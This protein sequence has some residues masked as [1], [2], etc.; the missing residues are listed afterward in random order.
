[1]KHWKID[2]S[3]KTADGVQEKYLFVEAHNIDDALAKAHK[4]VATA[5]LK[6]S[7]AGD[8]FVIWDVGMMEEEVF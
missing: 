6:E 5:E 2:Y 1:M 8:M 3:L 7:K 4:A